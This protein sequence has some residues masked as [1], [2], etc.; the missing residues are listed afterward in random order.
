MMEYPKFEA[1]E[2]FPTLTL[3]F[4]RHSIKEKSD[5]QDAG[6]HLS[7]EGR[8]QAVDRYEQ[9]IDLRFGHVVGSP[10]LRTKETAF[11]AATKDQSQEIENAPIGKIREDDRLDFKAD[12]NTLLGKAMYEAYNNKKTLSYYVYE[13]DKL[14]QQHHDVES[15]TYLRMAGNI[16]EILLENYETAVRGKAILEQSTNQNNKPNDFERILGSHQGVLESFLLR[17]CE[18]VNGVEDRDKLLSII[19]EEGFGFNEGFDVVFCK[20]GSDIA[21]E[22][23]YK[24]GDFSLREKIIPDIL[25]E[26]VKEGNG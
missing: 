26:M 19:G 3:H 14:A 6:V 21:I 12:E 22:I 18:K 24:K 20:D 7:E 25:S 17:Y 1:K 13:S 2:T 15:G 16:A 4:M 11:L 9:P 23:S 8:K 5:A 10:R